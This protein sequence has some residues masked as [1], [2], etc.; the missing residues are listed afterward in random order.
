[1][2]LSIECPISLLTSVLKRVDYLE[3][4]VP[5][6][7]DYCNEDA[8]VNQLFYENWT[9]VYEEFSRNQKPCFGLS[10]NIPQDPHQKIAMLE[11]FKNKVDF[12]PCLI[13]EKIQGDGYPRTPN[14]KFENRLSEKIRS[15]MNSEIGILVLDHS[16]RGPNSEAIFENFIK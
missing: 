13:S 3:L 14:I 9:L 10:V 1:M 8:L 11:Y 2:R 12:N 16:G 7:L 15:Q 4:N 5:Q 6:N